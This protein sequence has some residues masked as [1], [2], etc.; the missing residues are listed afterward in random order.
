[1]SHRDT[2]TGKLLDEV[3]YKL[4]HQRRGFV[5]GYCPDDRTPPPEWQDR[6]T[7][8]FPVSDTITGLYLRWEKGNPWEPIN[9]WMVDQIYPIH[10]IDEQIRKELLGDSPRTHGHYCAE[11]WCLCPQKYDGWRGGRVSCIDQQQWEAYRITGC[12][13]VRYWA[14]QGANGGHKYRLNTQEAKIAHIKTGRNSTPALGDLPYAEFSEQTLDKLVER[15][16]VRMYANVAAWGSDS[17]TRGK[18]LDEEDRAGVLE[19]NELL[20]NWLESQVKQTVDEITEKDRLAIAA[21]RPTGIGKEIK[22]A[23]T[24][25]QEQHK[26]AFLHEGVA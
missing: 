22:R 23:N 11:G 24:I 10:A 2:E 20:W 25:R 7:R 13:H 12:Y 14:I 21:E 18:V 5:D 26:Q 4:R 1:M 3:Y 16:R 9:R 17:E 15:D 6:L 19:A 8:L